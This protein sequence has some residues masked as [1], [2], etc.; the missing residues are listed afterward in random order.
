MRD[1]QDISVSAVLS[2]QLAGC[3]KNQGQ[4]KIAVGRQKCLETIVSLR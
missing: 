4:L 3:R 1:P 2:S